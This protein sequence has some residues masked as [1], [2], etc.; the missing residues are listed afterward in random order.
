MELIKVEKKLDFTVSLTE[1]D[2]AI[3]LDFVG[4]T[5]YGEDLERFKELHEGYD[6][7]FDNASEYADHADKLFAE[8]HTLLDGRHHEEDC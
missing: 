1:K 2:V 3:I 6:Y 7:L 8:M 4:S 5:N